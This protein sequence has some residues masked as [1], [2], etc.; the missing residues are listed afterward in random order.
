MRRILKGMAV[1][2]AVTILILTGCPEV[3]LEP[4]GTG[5]PDGNTSVKFTGLTADGSE[6]ATTTKLTLTFDKDI[7]GLSA[8][9]VIMD[10]GSTGTIKGSLTRTDMGTYELAVGVNAGGSVTV[11]VSK[12]GYVIT[13]GPKT[14]TVYRYVSP[15]DILVN[16]TDLKADGSATAATTKLTL[17]FDK[18]I[19]GLSAADVIM[20]AGTTGA[21]IGG[22]TKTGQGVYELAVAGISSDGSV[23]VAVSKS[24][25]NISGGPKT[26]TVYYYLSSTGIDVTFI[27]LTADG[28]ATATTTKLILTFDKD[29]EGLSAADINIIT[30]MTMGAVGVIKGDLTRTGIGVYELALSVTSVSGHSIMG[31]DHIGIWVNKSGYNIIISDNIISIRAPIVYI[32]YYLVTVP[33]ITVQPQSANYYV[34]TIDRTNPIIIS[35]TA[36]LNVGVTGTISYQWYRNTSASNTGGTPLN[37]ATTAVNELEIATE[38]TYYYYVVVTNNNTEES[39]TSNTATIKILS[40]QDLD[41]DNT[42]TVNIG[43]KY[44]YVRGFGVMA[45]FWAASPQ[46][47]IE[48]Y[49]KMLNPDNLGYNMLRVMVPADADGGSTDMREI[50]RKAVNNELSGDKDRSHY[51]DIVKLANKYGGYVLASPWSPP[52]VWK[53]NNSIFGGAAGWGAA[54]LKKEYWQDYADYLAEYCKIMYENG[55]PIYTITIQ[56]EP[57][58]IANYDGCEWTPEEMRDFF[59][60]VG[61]FTNGVKGWG[62]GKEIPSVRTMNGESANSPSINIPVLNDPTA[63][64]YVDLFGRHIYGNRNE[65]ISSRVHELGKEIWMTELNINSQNESGYYNDSTWDYVWRF[66]NTID[67]T[68]RLNKENAYIWWYGKRFYSMIGDGGYGTIEGEI[69]PRGHAMS[70]FAKFAKDTGQVGVTVTG[71]ASGSNNT[72]YDMDSTNAK[73]MAFVTLKDE[74]YAKPVETRSSR[75]DGKGADAISALTVDNITAISLVMFTPTNTSGTGGTNMQTVKIELPAGFNIR[76]TQ[77]MRST[78]TVKSQ[79]EEVI[80]GT[81]RNSAYVTLPAGEILSVRFTR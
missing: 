9:D 8:A 12:S 15:T 72:S 24:G 11:T 34:G 20:D 79:Y 49:E 27:S 45:N 55:A 68:L 13:D 75:W 77:A 10:A 7:E 78:S 65:T 36:T 53:T 39:I 25:Y 42:V 46:D 43:T 5:N 19:D 47:S 30:D 58:Y 69:L 2:T 29:I 70:H 21:I 35:V 4:P 59:K 1:I 22:L 16:F 64:Q 41:P 73:I 60:T 40:L 67:H 23:A 76:S 80:V 61:R 6:T 57:N 33:V 37:Y 26:V 38:G 50:M 28:S 48:D 31:S 52:A 44:Q 56:A 3:P 17:T 71:S 63:Y 62:G 51:Y 18:D 66:L 54:N 81:D 14:V 32:Y 74:F